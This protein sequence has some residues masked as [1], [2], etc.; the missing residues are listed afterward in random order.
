MSKPNNRTVAS[1]MK[2]TEK[3]IRFAIQI[4]KALNIE[5][6]KEKSLEDYAVYIATNLDEFR[7]QQGK[8]RKKEEQEKLKTRLLI[9]EVEP[10]LYLKKLGTQ[11]VGEQI[12]SID[13]SIKFMQSYVK[14]LDRERLICMTLSL[15]N[16]VIN[17][18]TISIGTINNTVTTGREIFKVA[19]LSN[20]AKIILFHNHPD[21]DDARPSR[22]DAAITKDCITIGNYLGIPLLDHVILS[23][24]YIYSFQ[25]KSMLYD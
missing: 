16:T 4:S 8:H 13:A 19:I 22:A 11:K 12:D 9:Q 24:N 17:I 25:E 7:R 20:A 21:V 6:P 15:D 14:G 1:E 5:L 10:R 2:P 3:Q 18:S 23:G